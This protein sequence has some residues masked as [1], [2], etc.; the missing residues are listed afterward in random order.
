VRP[1]LLLLCLAGL[2]SLACAPIHVSIRV[3]PG[4]NVAQYATYVQAPPPEDD[5]DETHFTP[6]IAVRMQAE[7]DR[8]LQQKGYRPVA[9]AQAQM[10]V[11]Y[12]VTG[13]STTRLVNAG[14]PDAD[15]YV[16]ETLIDGTLVIDV[17]DPK[18]GE[19]FW[20]GTGETE[21][22]TSG[23]LFTASSM[24]TALRAVRKVLHHFPQS[25][26]Q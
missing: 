5:P 1:H 3:E 8:I 7:I 23:T 16:N 20:H 19:R 14:D 24:S 2:L 9:E 12:L 10:R 25:L 13:V 22:V 11:A 26:A 15:Y 21:I 18:S 17:L 6:E 4:A